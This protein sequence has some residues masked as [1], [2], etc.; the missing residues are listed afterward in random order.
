MSSPDRMCLRD[1]AAP[2]RRQLTVPA[3]ALTSLGALLLTQVA[4]AAPLEA[5]GRLPSLENLALSPDGSRVALVKTQ[6]NARVVSV[7]SIA[8]RRVLSELRVGN[9]KL[10]GIEWADDNYL[11]LVT[12]VTTVPLGFVGED[13]EWFQIQLYDTRNGARFLIPGADTFNHVELMN[14]VHGEAVVRRVRG[15]TALFVPA[16]TG[17]FTPVLVRV[18]LDTRQSRVVRFGGSAT[19]S[20]LVDETGEV[21]AE[22][23]YDQGN[24]RWSI[25][26]RREGQMQEAVSGEE[27]IDF[28]RMLGWGPAADT[29]LLQTIEE[30]DAVWKLLSIKDGAI[31]PPLAQ[32]KTLDRPIEDRISHRM[33]G[34][35]HLDDTVQY[36][37]FDPAVQ[38]H[39]DAI[40]RAYPGE[41]LRLES[42]SAGLRKL[43]V[44]VEGA[45]DGFRYDLVDLDTSQ[46]SVV[47]EVYE[48]V[49]RPLEVRRVTYAAADGTQIP[50]YLTLPRDKPPK[51]LPLIVLPH[52]GPATRDMADFDWW[53]QALADQGYAVLQP[54][55]RGS[56]LNRKFL[57]A[58][59]GQWGRKMQTDLS[60][61]VRFLARDGIAD[62]ARV[63]I[64]GASYGG[65]AALAGVSLDPGVYRCAVAVA[66][67]ADLKRFLSWVNHRQVHREN[68]TQRYWDRFMGIRGPDDPTLEGISPIR[69]I[70]AIN[71]PVLLIHGRDDTVVPFEQSQA[72]YD[73]LRGAKKD[74]QLVTLKDEDH[75]LS[76]SG[77]R[78]QMLEASVAFLRAHD[79]PD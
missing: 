74:V 62:P 60:D 13:Y 24:R 35:V 32:R 42:A 54:N 15:H 19:V 64:V 3:V 51:N 39:W 76:R 34:G 77:T 69:H 63:C 73:A 27:A 57:T 47:G 1:G 6:Q 20:W 36:V 28:P 38:A 31:G 30:G 45:R 40:L 55:Y 56:D 68:L 46:S 29:V 50:G 8:E 18:D 67:I 25:H 16:L 10:R 4:P 70:D 72:M 7:F 44:R 21:A 23:T 59:F 52:G 17:R 78:L 37:F 48:G 2:Q 58:G 22:E 11:M 71:A 79:P 12:S 5:Y 14:T 61:G 26:I 9:Q 41:R 49:T 66:G 33:I 43:I 65:Y 53:P 75:W